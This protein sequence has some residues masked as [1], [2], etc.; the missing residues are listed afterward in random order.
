MKLS[1][2]YKVL[3]NQLQ[4]F[5]F[6]GMVIFRRKNICGISTENYVLCSFE[7]KKDPIFRICAIR[8][9]LRKNYG[10]CPISTYRL[11]L[12]GWLAGRL[13]GN[14]E[15]SG[16]GRDRDFRFFAIDSVDDGGWNIQKML[17]QAPLWVPVL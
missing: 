11:G 7:L 9:D 8:M 5:D 3:T 15:I 12:A 10:F 17:D 4:K 13:A 1:T 14:A 6:P 16:L 2:A